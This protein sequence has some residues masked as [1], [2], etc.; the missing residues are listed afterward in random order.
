MK[1]IHLSHKLEDLSSNFQDPIV[2]VWSHGIV[3][4]LG[5]EIHSVYKD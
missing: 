4:S 1:V 3:Y 2:R 5:T